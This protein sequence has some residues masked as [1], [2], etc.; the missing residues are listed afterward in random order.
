MDV[1]AVGVL[2]YELLVG[3]PPFE[4]RDERETAFRIMFGSFVCPNHL[5]EDV[6][7]FIDM[8]RGCS[9]GKPASLGNRGNV[10]VE[11]V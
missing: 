7:N 10:R 11:N 4:V 2:T 9:L 5:S 8:V 1:W 6:S 3:R